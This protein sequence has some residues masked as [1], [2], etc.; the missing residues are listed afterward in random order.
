M[1]TEP[2]MFEGLPPGPI[3]PPLPVPPEAA[4]SE[5]EWQAFH[6]DGAARRRAVAAGV[7]ARTHD[8]PELV[9]WD[10]TPEEDSNDLRLAIHS[11]MAM[12]LCRAHGTGA[13]HGQELGVNSGRSAKATVY[14]PQFV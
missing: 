10:G 11:E 13:T 8:A 1:T 5:E 12:N 4:A 2:A 3:L 7:Q 14:G 9:Q 6:E